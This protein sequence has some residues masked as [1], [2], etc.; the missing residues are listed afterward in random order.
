M[1]SPRVTRTVA[2]RQTDHL[3]IALGLENRV[4]VRS[5]QLEDLYTEA[6]RISSSFRGSHE[7]HLG[8]HV[9]VHEAHDGRHEDRVGVLPV[10]QERDPRDLI[11]RC[12]DGMD[13]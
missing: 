9:V 1:V 5:T 10:S 6:G 13:Q 7:A 8:V 2:Q 11:G 4:Q 12:A 3:Q